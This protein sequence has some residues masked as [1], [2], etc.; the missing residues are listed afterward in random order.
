MP[1]YSGHANVRVLSGVPGRS[2]MAVPDLTFNSHAFFVMG[3]MSKAATYHK[4][5][6]NFN[7]PWLSAAAAVLGHERAQYLLQK[8]AKE[9]SRRANFLSKAKLHPEVRGKS[10]LVVD[11]L[12]VNTLHSG[13]TQVWI[14]QKLPKAAYK[15]GITLDVVTTSD[16]DESKELWYNMTYRRIYVFRESELTADNVISVIRRYKEQYDGVLTWSEKFVLLADEISA[17]L[18]LPVRYLGSPDLKPNDKLA[19]RLMLRS[20][21]ASGNI[22]FALIHPTADLATQY[23][24]VINTVGF[25]AFVKPAISYGMSGG[26]FGVLKSG[27]L[28]NAE[29]LDR[30]VRR[31]SSHPRYDEMRRMAQSAASGSS[32]LL[33]PNSVPLIAEAFLKGAEV[34]VETVVFRGIARALTIR[35]T[36]ERE[37][38]EGDDSTFWTLPAALTPKQHMKCLK[39]AA[40]AVSA[41]KLRN[42]VYGIQL[43]NDQRLGCTFLEVNLRPHQWPLL[44]D[45]SS[46]FFFGDE[47]WSYGE[48]ALLIALGID[49]ESRILRKNLGWKASGGAL[50]SMSSE[51]RAPQVLYPQWLAFFN[52]KKICDTRF[53]LQPTIA[54]SQVQFPNSSV[55]ELRHIKRRARIEQS[56]QRRKASR[57]TGQGYL[58]SSHQEVSMKGDVLT[59]AKSSQANH[60]LTHKKASGLRDMTSMNKA[61]RWDRLRPSLTNDKT[62]SAQL[63]SKQSSSPP[64]KITWPLQW[65]SANHSV[66]SWAHYASE[67]LV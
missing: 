23:N 16:M 6:P 25:P 55:A 19:M 56:T 9:A 43:V 65:L 3:G 33:Q 57:E 27:K 41:L 4:L 63:S 11:C 54:R 44:V 46:Q 42:G 47:L 66:R 39:V 31:I 58:R 51:C 48:V 40:D 1:S 12:T 35:A 26:L 67:R 49:P 15:L 64:P 17:K 24:A 36:V 10:V 61:K 59:K 8:N 2:L 62:R 28:L 53:A 13:T 30:E 60:L 32:S 18:R 37:Q 20:A 29:Q 50:V 38:E 45:E 14:H 52:Y 5:F 7:R 34:F 22:P 21:N